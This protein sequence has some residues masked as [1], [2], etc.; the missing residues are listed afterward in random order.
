MHPGS[1][2]S[3]DVGLILRLK[4]KTMKLINPINLYFERYLQKEL[5]KGFIRTIRVR[6]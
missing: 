2:N 6:E 1:L 3:T 4:N 5:V